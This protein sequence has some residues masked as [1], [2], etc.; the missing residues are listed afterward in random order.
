MATT[1]TPP[2]VMHVV[3]RL[4]MGGL[5]NGLVN[6]INHMPPGRYRHAIVCL[7]DFTDFRER[8][9]SPSVSVLALHKQP[10][11]DWSTYRR[12]WHIIRDMNPTIVHTRNLPTLEIAALAA[13]AGVPCRIHGEHGRDI[14]DQY[15][16]SGKFLIFRKILRR[17]VNHYVAVS[18]DLEQW[19]KGKVKIAPNKVKQIYNGVD[20]KIFYPKDFQR[21][22]ILPPGFA[23]SEQLVIGTVGRLQRVKDQSTLVQAFSNLVKSHPD[24]AQKVRLVIVGDGSLRNEVA[25]TVRHA[26]VGDMVWMPGERGDIPRVLQS[27]DIFVLPSEAEGISNTILEAMATGLPVIATRVGGNAELVL[28]GETGQLIPPKDPQAL[29]LALLTYVQHPDLMRRHGEGGRSRVEQ[30]FSL[31]A[32]V[33]SYLKL[34][35]GLVGETRPSLSFQ[36]SVALVSG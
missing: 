33:E 19:L 29:A 7:T 36:S 31:S 11:M 28:E 14:H 16:A 24:L 10:G 25:Q 17:I 34:Y 15:G 21:R 30:E 23:N 32:M 18:R 20:T 12:L 3:Y 9:C 22:E 2:L 4:A 35:D 1:S 13:L 6:L 26:H 8:L 5:E 27:F